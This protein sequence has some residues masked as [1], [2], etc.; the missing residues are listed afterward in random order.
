MVY[1]SF[2]K[3]HSVGTHYV[4]KYILGNTEG[5]KT[6]YEPRDLLQWY[7]IKTSMYILF[8]ENL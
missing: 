6:G 1:G 3:Q 7:Q 5:Y 8:L 2:N 4:Q